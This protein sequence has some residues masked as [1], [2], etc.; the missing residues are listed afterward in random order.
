M[1]PTIRPATEADLPAVNAIYNHYVATSTCTFQYEPET[2]A[3]RRAWFISRTAAH[4]VVVAEA[5]GAVVGWAALSP[6]KSRVGYAHSVEF[7][8]YVHPDHHRRGIGRA[9]VADLVE[10]ARAAGHHTVIGGACTEHP[11]SIALQESLG[12]VP[13]AHFRETGYKFGRWLDV[14]YFQLMLRMED[15]PLA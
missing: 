11:A 15:S 7:S 5:D 2:V 13:V 4:P 6:W 12:F 3:E 9:L 14:V 1:P 8:V 10:R